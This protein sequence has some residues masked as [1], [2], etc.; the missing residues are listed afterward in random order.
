MTLL[1]PSLKGTVLL[2]FLFC[3]NALSWSRNSA[4]CVWTEKYPKNEMVKW[5]RDPTTT[6]ALPITKRGACPHHKG[7]LL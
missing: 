1:F 4:R 6:Y 2:V 3:S 7:Q 5:L